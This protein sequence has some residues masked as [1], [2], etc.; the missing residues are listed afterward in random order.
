MAP[1]L[2]SAA[3]EIVHTTLPILDWDQLKNLLD[4]KLMCRQCL[5]T[6]QLAFQDPT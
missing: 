2:S 1:S 6:F 3:L 5:E 4:T